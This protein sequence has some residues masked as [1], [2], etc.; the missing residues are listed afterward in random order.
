MYF[1]RK[2]IP[3]C[4]RCNP[5]L[6]KEHLP[7][8]KKRSKT[9]WYESIS[10]TATQFR[11]KKQINDIPYRS[12]QFWFAQVECTCQAGFG[13]HRR[14]FFGDI[15]RLNPAGHSPNSNETLPTSVRSQQATSRPCSNLSENSP[16]L[17]ISSWRPSAAA[18]RT[19]RFRNAHYSMF[20][21]IMLFAANSA[22]WT[23]DNHTT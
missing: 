22:R 1:N 13:R 10:Y 6:S 19:R 7:K 8:P 18:R 17:Q 9:L 5:N 16:T 2:H 11:E 21:S 23:R 3:G 12:C 20:T 4:Y 15:S 14:F